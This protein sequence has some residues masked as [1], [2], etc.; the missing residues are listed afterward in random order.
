MASNP[1]SMEAD[2]NKAANEASEDF[3]SMLDN[4]AMT[5]LYQQLGYVYSEAICKIMHWSIIWANI[6]R[7]LP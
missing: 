2:P 4:N 7:A 1:S 5:S 6:E 3:F